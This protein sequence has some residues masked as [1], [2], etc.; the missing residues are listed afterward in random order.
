MTDSH[1]DRRIGD[2]SDLVKQITA[3]DKVQADQRIG[4]VHDSLMSA[5]DDICRKHG[6]ERA[7][8]F[9]QKQLNALKDISF[10][11]VYILDKKN[12]PPSNLLAAAYQLF[13]RGSLSDKLAIIG[14]IVTIITGLVGPLSSAYGYVSR[15]RI[16]TTEEQ[17]VNT[18]TSS[19]PE[20]PTSSSKSPDPE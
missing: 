1:K 14:L 3:L 6:A 5:I 15:L 9:N 16:S 17:G 13:R 4:F 12:H 18:S 2:A 8:V 19:E 20:V 10:H 11:I 7:A